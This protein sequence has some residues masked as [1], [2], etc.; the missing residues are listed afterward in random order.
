[1]TKEKSSPAQ[2]DFDVVVVGTGFAGIYALWQARQ[3]GYTV[4][5]FERAPDVGGT[6]YW[7]TYPGARCDVES[8]NYAYFFD[9]DIVRE[10]DWSD[11]CAAQ[12]E[13]QR[14]LRFVA[15]KCGVLG[16]VSFNSRVVSATFDE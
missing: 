16:D 6:W 5:G 11:A 15:E 8:Y 2:I 12:G 7:N 14:Y 3:R 1:M 13:I 10:W 4:K 9:N